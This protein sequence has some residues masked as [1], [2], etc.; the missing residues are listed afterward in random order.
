M[1]NEENKMD[2]LGHVVNLEDA[3]N[4]KL[5]TDE[6]TL[7]DNE[8]EQ[9]GLVKTS[10]FVRSNRSK[11]ALRI[12]KHKEKKAEIG[13]K[14]LNIEVPEQYRDTLKVI[15]SELKD[16]KTLEEAIKTA[17]G[18]LFQAKPGHKD[19]KTPHKTPESHKSVLAGKYVDIGNKCALIASKG[20]IKALLLKFII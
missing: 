13:I 2:F 15:A 6:K 5:P 4:V 9:A 1:K 19:K 10:A 12:E 20:G 16:G 14:Q 3:Q 8:L 11:N 7:S 18:N 17:D